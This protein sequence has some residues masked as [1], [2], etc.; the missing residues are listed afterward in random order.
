MV[1]PSEQSMFPKHHMLPEFELAKNVVFP[2][3]QTMLPKSHMLS[4][5]ELAMM[6]SMEHH[7]ATRMMA[8]G[9]MVSPISSRSSSTP[10][11]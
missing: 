8:M 3:K 10:S 6:I 4:M 11:Y 9:Q 1:F 7:M 2:S 5:F